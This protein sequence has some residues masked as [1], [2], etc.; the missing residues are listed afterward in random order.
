MKNIYIDTKESLVLHRVFKKDL[1][2]LE[3]ILSDY[4]DLLLEVE[5]LNE[6]VEDLEQDIREN[7]KKI[8]VEEQFF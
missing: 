7:Y 3:E 6:K 8:D 4:E 2:S 5:Y 1:V